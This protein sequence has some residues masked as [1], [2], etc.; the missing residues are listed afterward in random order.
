MRA[1][2]IN[3]SKKRGVLYKM[4]REEDALEEE[5]RDGRPVHR[6][7]KEEWAAAEDGRAHAVAAEPGPLPSLGR[8]SVSERERGDTCV[9]SSA[10]ALQAGGFACKIKELDR[11]GD[12]TSSTT[13]RFKSDFTQ[14]EAR[15]T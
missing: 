2:R 12:Q 13:L 3:Q 6:G 10:A 8:Q 1:C 11:C 14:G 4:R 7:R 9:L 15:H 5:H